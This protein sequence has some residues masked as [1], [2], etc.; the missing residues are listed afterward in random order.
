MDQQDQQEQ[1]EQQ[2]QRDQQY[3]RQAMELAEK[4]RGRTSP[5]PLVG[6]LIVKEGKV[7]GKGYHKKHGDHHAEVNAFNSTKEKAEGATLYVT[8]EPCFHYGNTPPC[9]DR[10]IEEGIR[11]VVI[12]LK[13]P[14]PLVGGKSIEKLKKRGIEVREGVLEEV[15]KEQNRIFLEYIQTQ[16]PYTVIKTA[17]SL[18]GKIATS[19][20]E[21]QWITGEKARAYV[22]TLRDQMS[23]IMVGVGTVIEDD[24]SLT[25]RLQDQKGK[26]PHRIVVDT[27]GR[28]P[29]TAKILHLD[30]E[31]KTI[32]AS[33]ELMEED[34]KKAL[35]DLGATVLM[36]P[37]KN[38]RV[39][40]KH[41]FDKLGEQKIDSVLV[42]GGATLNFS[43]VEEALVH[44]IISFIAPKIIGGESAKTP[45]GGR[46]ILRM[47][48]VITLNNL[49]YKHFGQDLMIQG[50]IR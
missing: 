36:S 15:L 18:D 31:A 27:R 24:P 32:I 42:E 38:E 9:V 7:I 41:L 37:I 29:L 25:T 48:D 1:Q 46:G 22:H 5:N 23:G 20:G 34:K 19:S 3:M 4:A 44:R 40:L 11:R 26:D 16:K 8:L 49:Q 21:S 6:A 47:E 10:V 39:D 33:T 13:D 45:I 2:E 17:M 35:E 14:N 30:S 12:G 43:L 28:I 50:D